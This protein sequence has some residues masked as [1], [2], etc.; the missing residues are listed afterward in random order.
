MS[1]FCACQNVESNPD[2][3]ACMDMFE[4]IYIKCLLG[5]SHDDS[6]LTYCNR[7]YKANIEECPCQDNCPNGCPCPNYAC[8]ETTSLI[9]TTTA[10]TTMTSTTTLTTKRVGQNQTVLALNNNAGW[11][12]ALIDSNGRQEKLGCFVPD[13]VS[14]AHQSCGLTWENNMYIFGGKFNKRQISR[15]NRYKLQSI[16]RLP[17]DFKN[18][19]C[20]NMADQ[21]FFLCFDY[22]DDRRCHWST[23]PLGSFNDVPLASYNHKQ[24]RIS[25]SECK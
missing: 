21:K 12:A 14:E 3:I 19:A 22:N 16:G 15:L 24:I 10:A 2:Y 17:F 13:L 6:C 9:T 25:S 8:Q 18:G 11:Q 1:H 7:E 4:D 23:E 20:T 5:C